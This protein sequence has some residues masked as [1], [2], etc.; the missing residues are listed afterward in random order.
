MASYHPGE[1]AVQRRANLESSAARSLTAVR[2]AVP[3]VAAAFLAEQPFVVAGAAD[4]EGRLWA[5]LLRGQPGFLRLP[6]PEVLVVEARPLPEDP[7]APVLAAPAPIGMIA[8]E[9]ARR[10]RMRM[11]GRSQPA[12]EGL[13]VAL[14]Q[15]IPNCPKY[16]QQREYTP[17]PVGDARRES[18]RSTRLSAAQRAAI[19][20][21]DTFFVATAS[22]EGAADASHRGGNPGFVQVLSPTRLRWPD[23]RGNAMFLTLGNLEL[24]PRAGLVVP[25]WTGGSLLQLTGTA[26]TVWD[27]EAAARVPGAERLVD[28]A[29]EEVH[30]I[31]HAVPLGW[32]APTYWRFNPPVD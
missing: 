23:Y 30:E 20:A 29:V 22:P 6:H 13:R 25:D 32:S 15:V 1:L 21:A 28:F 16:L 31:S 10:R 18:H 7:L 5:T 9:P 2:S 12:G 8:I 14:D 26:R 3:P 11:N 27:P 17:L 24:N 19:T 4:A